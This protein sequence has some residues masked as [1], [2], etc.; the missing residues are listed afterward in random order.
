MANNKEGG[1]ETK[2]K[3][4]KGGEEVWLLSDG[5]HA[6]SNGK[7]EEMRQHEEQLRK[8]INILFNTACE[9][10]W[11][12]ENTAKR[13]SEELEI[14]GWM[15][16]VFVRVLSWLVACRMVAVCWVIIRG[17]CIQMLSYW[18]RNNSGRE[19]GGNCPRKQQ[20][21]SL[22]TTKLWLSQNNFPLSDKWGFQLWCQ[23]LR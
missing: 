20:E 3:R 17:C 18:S 23:W 14:R 21:T 8:G 2:M 12:E 11:E 10:E 16:S 7:G 5:A 22:T 4:L 19:E 6:S 9:E 15:C 1:N 13:L